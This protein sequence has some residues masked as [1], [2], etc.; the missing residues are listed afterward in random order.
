VAALNGAPEAGGAGKPVQ[1]TRRAL[2]ALVRALASRG[3]ESRQGRLSDAER[4]RREGW[5]RV[6]LR[7]IDRFGLHVM[8]PGMAGYPEPFRDL[9][10]PPAAVFGA[11][12][13][14][15]LGTPMVAI[16]GTRSCT[17][18]GLD[19]AGRIARGL[20]D[21]GVTVVSGLALGIDGAAHRAAG[22][23]RTV[24][25]VGCGLDVAYPPR[26]RALQRAIARQGLL[27]SEHLPGAP[28][29]GFHFPRRN[30][31]IAA[32]ASAVVVVEAPEKSGALITADHALELGR[33][34]LAV[35]GPRGAGRSSGTNRLIE[36]GATVVTTARE[37][38]DV[39]GLPAGGL[40][41]EADPP[42]LDLHGVGLALWRSLGPD[43]R[44]VDEVVGDLGLDPHYG[45]ASL[46]ALE[47][48]GY[49]RKLPGMRFTR[50]E[51]L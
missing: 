2:E 18:R 1:P 21:A 17:G 44:H 39:L 45:L 7:T 16:V 19:Q 38:L 34:V 25:V 11:G 28:P 36:E 24:A 29:F 50:R 42:P 5:A 22:A 47:I 9:H 31:M 48:Q 3:V 35:P 46:L 27:L 43:P 10:D 13:L 26:H 51:R 8:T 14:A 15:L 33:A 20:A 41:G 23:A 4:E 49:A 12:A 40:A 37:V 32:L 30:R 6:A